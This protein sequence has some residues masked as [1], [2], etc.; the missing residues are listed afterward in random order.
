MQASCT[1]GEKEIRGGMINK[2]MS[3]SWGIIEV[4]ELFSISY[5][6]FIDL[7]VSTA[8]FPY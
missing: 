2:L 7:F 5:L 6:L 1:P 4:M 3:R 8:Y